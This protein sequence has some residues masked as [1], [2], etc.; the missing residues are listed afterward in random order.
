VPDQDAKL[1]CSPT[2]KSRFAF[3]LIML[4]A[5]PI[6]RAAPFLT[7]DVAA[8]DAD[9]CVFTNVTMGITRESAVVVDKTRGNAATGYRVCKEDMAGWPAGPN[10]VSLGFRRSKDGA[11]STLIIATI[12][13]SKVAITSAKTTSDTGASTPTSTRAS[14]ST[15]T[16]A[17]SSGAA[18]SSAS[19]WPATAPAGVTDGGADSAVTVGV[20]ITPSVPGAIIG[21][22]FYKVAS[23]SGPHVGNLWTNSG[24]RLA[25]VTFVNETASGWQTATL[26]S[27]IAVSAGETYVASYY[28]PVG[29]YAFTPNYFKSTFDRAPLSAPADTLA[30]PNGL[31]LHGD[32]PVF[33]TL[34]D[35]QG[36][37]WVDVIF[38]ES[39]DAR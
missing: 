39:K 38:K 30:A 36:N 27:P 17:A 24:T 7:S 9:L 19:L 34:G 25:T 18:K 10:E 5:A 2:M 4:A 33:P 31:I 12:D 16:A 3:V 28:S 29:H 8:P 1:I 6:V 14:T 32:K 35:R 22:R 23:N 26:A 37:Y 20:R 15:S 13:K 11:R 21:L